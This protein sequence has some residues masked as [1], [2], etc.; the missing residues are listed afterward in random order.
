MP[1]WA[2]ALFE[3]D[4]TGKVN[5]ETKKVLST[6]YNEENENQ[7]NIFLQSFWF[8]DMGMDAKIIF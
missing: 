5:N 7:I 1:L 2:A 8:D 6:S 3:Y 4:V